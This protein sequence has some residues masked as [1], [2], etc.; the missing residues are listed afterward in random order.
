MEWSHVVV[1]VVVC[2]SHQ[3]PRSG[4][5]RRQSAKSITIQLPVWSASKG[6]RKGGGCHEANNTVVVMAARCRVYS[7]NI[8]TK[9]SV[10]CCAQ[11]WQYCSCHPWQ[12][13]FGCNNGRRTAIGQLC[14]AAFNG[15]SDRILVDATD[16]RLVA[17]VAEWLFGEL[18]Q[19]VW[20]RVP[21]VCVVPMSLGADSSNSG[22]YADITLCW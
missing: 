11:L 22:R 20:S 19:D 18:F 10:V 14:S 7:I 2:L 6:S 17:G 5:S 3:S 15:S 8:L 9:D 13:L 1:A 12:C 4:V 16:G 21:I